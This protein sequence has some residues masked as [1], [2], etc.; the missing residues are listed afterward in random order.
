MAEAHERSTRKSTGGRYKR[1]SKR[2]K[3]DLV[4]KFA[5][6]AKG[7]LKTT[8]RKSRGFTNKVML[9][10]ADTVSVSKPDGE[11]VT[12]EIEDVVENTANPD[13]VRRDILTKGAVVS[14]SEGRVEIT[15]R[16][17]QDGALNG[18]LLEE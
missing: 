11:T 7:E 2:K 8:D 12:A 5:A 15:S 1:N 3:R 17:G 14:T 6:T 16:P 13:F 9:K 4:G 10:S 18:K